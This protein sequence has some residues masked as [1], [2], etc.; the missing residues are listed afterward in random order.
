MWKISWE[1]GHEELGVVSVEMHG[2]VFKQLY[3][4]SQQPWVMKQRRY[5]GLIRSKKGDK[6]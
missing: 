6:F 3:S 4:A 2:M 1:E 5:S